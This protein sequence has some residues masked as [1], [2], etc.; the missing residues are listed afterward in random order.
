M[1]EKFRQ[2]FEPG[3][4]NPA[5]ETVEELREKVERLKKEIEINGGFEKAP[6]YLIGE[7]RTA[8]EELDRAVIKDR[9]GEK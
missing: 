9:E 8:Q 5:E 1:A 7:Y 4:E 2:E 6:T 3:V